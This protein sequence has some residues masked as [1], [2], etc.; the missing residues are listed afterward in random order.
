MS[1]QIYL[2]NTLVYSK[3]KNGNRGRGKYNNNMF[4]RLQC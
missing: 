1:N 2:K 3:R 4:T